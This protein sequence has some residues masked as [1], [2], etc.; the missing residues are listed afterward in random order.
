MKYRCRL[1]DREGTEEDVDADEAWQAPDAY[2]YKHVAMQ[3]EGDVS[4]VEVLDGEWVCWCCT[5]VGPGLC[6]RATTAK[7]ARRFLAM[8]GAQS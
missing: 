4:F 5:A 1:L 3:F 2:V 6:T 7:A 8:K